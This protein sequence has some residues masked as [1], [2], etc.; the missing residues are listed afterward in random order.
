METL[1]T[2]LIFDELYTAAR[3]ELNIMCI[4]IAFVR[5]SNIMHRYS[6]LLNLPRRHQD[7]K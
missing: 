1:F 4:G 2:L 3:Q 6:T 5:R 7:S